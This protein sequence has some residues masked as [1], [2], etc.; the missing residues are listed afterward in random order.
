LSFRGGL[1]AVQNHL[2][3]PWR[4]G[5]CEG[6]RILNGEGFRLKKDDSVADQ[7]ERW[8]LEAESGVLSMPQICTL[9]AIT[10]ARPPLNLSIRP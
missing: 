9:G 3:A 7:G 4:K 10:A 1:Q 5:F 8:K 6:I 2:I